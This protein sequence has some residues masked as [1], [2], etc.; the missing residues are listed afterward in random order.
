MSKQ[1]KNKTTLSGKK[2]NLIRNLGVLPK[3]YKF[4]S[5]FFS[6]KTLKF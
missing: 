5:N 2:I 6:L 3:I 1:C 4:M